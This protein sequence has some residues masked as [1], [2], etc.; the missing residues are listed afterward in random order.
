MRY[1]A[2]EGSVGD[3]V[4]VCG[5]NKYGVKFSEKNIFIFQFRSK[6]LFM[7]VD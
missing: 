3:N 7:L 5:G 6:K 2:D 1:L 4:C